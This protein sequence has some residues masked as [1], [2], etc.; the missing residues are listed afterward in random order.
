MRLAVVIIIMKTITIMCFVIEN[1]HLVIYTSIDL[2]KNTTKY[3]D[4]TKWRA[5]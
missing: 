1:F 3:M 5:T 2:L 4:Q